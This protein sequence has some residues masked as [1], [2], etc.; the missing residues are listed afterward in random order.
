MS[1]YSTNKAPTSNEYMSGYSD[2]LPCFLKGSLVQMSDNMPK[3]IEDVR[4]GDLLMGAFGETNEVL[5]LHRPLLGD[6]LMCRINNEH[7]TTNDHP[8][9]SADR[10]FYCGDPSALQE[11]TYGH[12]H[13]V[14]LAD[15]TTEMRMLDG[16]KEGRV[17]TLE[18]GVILKTSYGEKEVKTMETYTMPPDTQ[19]YNLVMGGSHTYHVDRYAV[20]G[21]PSEND[22]DYDAWLPKA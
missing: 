2:T 9:V 16:L 4:V 6:G 11:K 8:H 13:E 5:A 15:W 10:K 17:Q 22:F 19:L 21:W 18:L 12:E 7:S 3:L 14:I 20:T 1:S